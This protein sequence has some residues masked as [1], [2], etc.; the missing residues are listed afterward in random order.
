MRF[1]RKYFVQECVTLTES[2]KLRHQVGTIFEGTHRLLRSLQSDL[3]AI[4]DQTKT[5]P[6]SGRLSLI[7]PRR[8]GLQEVGF[9]PSGDAITYS[10]QCLQPQ[11]TVISGRICSVE[12]NFFSAGKQSYV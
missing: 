2:G 7:W 3:S 10:Y 9:H 4:G 1:L 11:N 6:F 5:G 12:L 8:M